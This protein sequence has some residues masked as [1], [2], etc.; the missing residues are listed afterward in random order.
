MKLIVSLWLVLPIFNGAAYIYDNVVRKQLKVVD[1]FASS[2]ITGEQRKVLHMMS[3]DARRSVERYI[4]EYGPEAFETVLKAVR[5]L[6]SFNFCCTDDLVCSVFS[7]LRFA[8]E[9]ERSKFFVAG[10][11]GSEETPFLNGNPSSITC[12]TAC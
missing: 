9:Q 6:P 4:D 8:D 1:R 5:M 2:T 12:S 7:V 3:L 11:E 10:G